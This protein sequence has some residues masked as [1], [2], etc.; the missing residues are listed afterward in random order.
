MTR[1]KNKNDI[2]LIIFDELLTT[3]G[4]AIRQNKIPKLIVNL[5]DSN[6][7]KIVLDANLTYFDYKVFEGYTN[8]EKID[9]YINTFKT[10]SDTINVY[11]I[12][13]NSKDNWLDIYAAIKDKLINNKRVVVSITQKSYAEEIHNQLI[14]DGILTESECKYYHGNQSYSEENN[15]GETHWEMKARDFKNVEEAWKSIKLLIY[16]QTLVCGVNYN[17]QDDLYKFDT[18]VHVYLG[19]STPDEFM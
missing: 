2:D 4:H 16:T 1:I 10:Q 5:L 15:D 6:A 18:F 7:R 17:V 3:F 13:Q 12:E 19:V 11:P 14:K 8:N 9:V